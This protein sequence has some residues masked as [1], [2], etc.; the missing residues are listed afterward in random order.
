VIIDW[1]VQRFFQEFVS[2]KALQH[3]NVL[4]LVGVVVTDNE[5]ALVSEWMSNG[6]INQFVREHR[7]ANR[8]GLVSFTGCLI[9][10]SSAN[11][12][13]AAS[14]L[15]D[16]ARGLFYMHNLGLVHGDLKGVCLAMLEFNLSLE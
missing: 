2:W 5:F 6:N 14:Q 7:D 16:A 10:P 13:R 11:D 15:S 4:P 8:F 3:L 1:I 12:I 9:W